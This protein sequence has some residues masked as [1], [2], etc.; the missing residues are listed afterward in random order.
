MARE[1]LSNEILSAIRKA[2]QSY[3]AIHLRNIK[4]GTNGGTK[5]VDVTVQS[6]E[7]PDE[8]KNSIMIVFA[9]VA[10]PALPENTYFEIRKEISHRPRS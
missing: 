3:E 9:D 4:V 10:S 1:G 2:K 6:I 8:F 7:K 5:Y